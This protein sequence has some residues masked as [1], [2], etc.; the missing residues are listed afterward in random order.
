MFRVIV[1]AAQGYNPAMIW[2]LGVALAALLLLAPVSAIEAHTS[3]DAAGSPGAHHAGD[4]VAGALPSAG[5]PVLLILLALGGM[6]AARR[7]AILRS[8]APRIAC[9]AAAA[10]LVT[11]TAQ[12]SPHLVHHAV[13][14]DHGDSCK[15]KRLADLVVDLSADVPTAVPVLVGV[16]LLVAS[17][18]DHPTAVPLADRSRAPPVDR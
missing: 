12:A 17:P 15:I 6:L 10:L 5:V 2:R 4:G 16:P 3:I 14:Q 8:R 7:S 18:T 11:M 1:P 13:D 9:L